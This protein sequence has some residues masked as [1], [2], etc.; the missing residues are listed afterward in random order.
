M[1]AYKGTQVVNGTWGEVWINSR[2]LAEVVSLKATITL[3]K[4]EVKHNK[5]LAK[6]YKVMA[7]T[8]KAALKCIK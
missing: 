4:T 5:Q 7:M 2:Y 8:C 1:E 6:D 3:D